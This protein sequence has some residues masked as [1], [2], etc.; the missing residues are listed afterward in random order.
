MI[1][2]FQV[3]TQCRD[4]RMAN[5]HVVRD[6][7][8]AREFY[9][10]WLQPRRDLWLGL[11]SETNA[12]DP[13]YADYQ[14][15]TVQWADDREAWVFDAVSLGPHVVRHLMRGH[16]NLVA[17]FS[18]S[19]LNFIERGAPGSI[20]MDNDTYPHLWDIQVA[21]ACHDPRTIVT[22]NPKENIDPRIPHAKGLKPS[23]TR[24]LSPMLEQVENEF[25]AWAR[26]H[27]PKGYRVGEK[28]KRWKFGNVPFDEQLY[29]VYAA[30]DAL[31]GVR[32]WHKMLAEINQRG[33]WPLVEE[34]L[35]LQWDYDRAMFRGLPANEPYVRWLNGKLREV[36]SRNAEYLAHFHIGASGQGQAVATAF[37]QLG[38]PSTKSKRRRDGTMTVTYDKRVL[39][40]F[41][42]QVG[43]VGDLAGVVLSSR[44]ASKFG[45]T[46]VQPLLDAIEHGDG[47]VHPWLRA[48]GATTGRNSASGPP[49]Q[50]IPKKSTLARPMFGNVDDWIFVSSDMSQ[51]EPRTLASWTGDPNLIADIAGGDIN[52]AIA[53]TAFG[54]DFVRAD[55]KRAGTPS[56]LMRQGGKVGFLA[57]VY[58]AG[59]NK[60]DE[61]AGVVPG[62]GLMAKWRARYHVAFQHGDVLN[63]QPWVLLDSGRV[64]PLWDRYTVD[65]HDQ[66]RLYGKPSRLALNY[67]TQGT[68]RDY[69]LR[70]AWPRLRAW[71]WARYLAL[72]VHDE[73]VLLVPIPMAEQARQALESA[74]TFDLPHGVQMLCEATIDGPTWLPEPAAFNDHELDFVLD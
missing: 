43:P 56:Y 66:L 40:E 14:L 5:I 7:A 38:S 4:N 10:D 54:S 63:R 9:H 39:A 8:G 48:V 41:R 65:E 27:A 59:D 71:G 18:R 25:N 24:E 16:H 68:Q 20:D 52:S 50:Q 12:V 44:R 64:V 15:R 69:L 1:T 19:E 36:V 51:G 67:K 55:G 35:R 29:Q 49:V 23:A 53:A 37:E 6:L 22:A 42:K 32:Y 26:A 74:M 2:S 3:D 72:T 57:G 13:W 62:T 60:V 34:D 21:Q 61:E 58:G 70:V 47:R 11:D 28:L 33:Q 46:Y 73:I 31:F 45:S 30:V 17:H